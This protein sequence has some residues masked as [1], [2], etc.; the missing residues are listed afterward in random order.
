M[1]RHLRLFTVLMIMMDTY[2]F[3]SQIKFTPWIGDNYEKSTFGKRVLVLGESH[4]DWEKGKPIDERS[5]VT[6][7][8]IREQL[9]GTY[10]KAFWT[11]IAITF[12]NK[13]PTLEEKRAFWHQIAFYNYVQS[14][15]GF[16]PRKSPTSEQFGKSAQAFFELLE[17]YKPEV[18]IVLGKRLWQNLPATNR[19][20]TPKIRGAES[21]N[22][23]RFLYPGGS[24]LAVGIRHPSSGFNGR[25]WHS[26][27]ISAINHA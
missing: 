20:S 21:L 9:D 19:E 23:A 17:S 11:K 4:Y 13:Q 6:N 7:I 18:I 16:G 2:P 10:T 26:A 3:M 24:A 1:P 14:S 15:A 12:L 27:V 5:E 25:N 8:V 22:T